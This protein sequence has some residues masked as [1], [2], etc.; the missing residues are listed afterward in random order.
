MS[1]IFRVISSLERDGVRGYL[2]ATLEHARGCDE[3][4]PLTHGQAK[5]RARGP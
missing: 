1:T 4:N 3:A 2:V 5:K